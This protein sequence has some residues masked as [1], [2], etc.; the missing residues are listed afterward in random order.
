[1]PLTLGTFLMN[2]KESNITR[3]FSLAV[4]LSL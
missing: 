1:M 2:W 3:Y 4:Y